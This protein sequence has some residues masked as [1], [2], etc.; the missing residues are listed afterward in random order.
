M[1]LFYGTTIAENISA[2]KKDLKIVAQGYD[3]AFGNK[4]IFIAYGRPEDAGNCILFVMP[5][6]IPN[7]KPFQDKYSNYLIQL[8]G[9]YLLKNVIITSC[10][11]I[12]LEQVS[13]A[14]IKDFN[15]WM[16][17]IVDIFRP[18]LIVALGE[19]AQFS[20]VKRKHIL[21]D[22]HGQVI[23]QSQSGIDV[24]LSYAMN[25][26][27]E[28]SEY[29]DPSYKSFIQQNDWRIIQKYYNERIYESKN[30]SC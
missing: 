13:K 25:Y 1:D 14:N 11:L 30:I 10:F 5:P 21:R 16:E 26:Y 6:L 27:I 20:F 2:F 12:P 19:D 17:K 3:Y 28:K 9:R 15:P 29:E 22:Y 18:K 24:I 8:A 4:K 23:A 7:T